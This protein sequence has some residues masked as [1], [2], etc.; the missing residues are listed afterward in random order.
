MYCTFLKVK[1]TISF[2]Q[3]EKM[4]NILKFTMQFPHVFMAGAGVEESSSDH[5]GQPPGGHWPLEIP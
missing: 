2:V 5:S 1:S 4:E 3:V